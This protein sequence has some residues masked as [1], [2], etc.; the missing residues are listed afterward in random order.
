MHTDRI[1]AG[2]PKDERACCI[3]RQTVQPPALGGRTSVRVQRSRRCRSAGNWAAKKGNSAGIA[4]WN[5]RDSPVRAP[6]RAASAPKIRARKKKSAAPA[7]KKRCFH[8]RAI[9]FQ[10]VY[11]MHMPC[12]ISRALD[13]SVCLKGGEPVR[14][15][16]DRLRD[17]ARGNFLAGRFESPS[18]PCGTDRRP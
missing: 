7:G 17:F 12:G 2:Q 15:W 6:S 13:A 9:P 3:A 5:D 4:I 8:E 16:N 10:S 11:H 1:P 18:A 14:E